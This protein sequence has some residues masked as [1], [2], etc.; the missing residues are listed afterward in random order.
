MNQVNR[1]FTNMSFSLSKALSPCFPGSDP[2][3]VSTLL[4][5]LL[6]IFRPSLHLI[7]TLS[8]HNTHLQKRFPD[9]RIMC[10]VGQK[11]WQVWPDDFFTPVMKLSRAMALLAEAYSHQE[12][13]KELL[14]AQAP[15][16]E[17]ALEKGIN[18]LCSSIPILAI[19]Y[20]LIHWTI[21]IYVYIWI[22]PNNTFAWQKLAEA[23]K[24]NGDWTKAKSAFEKYYQ[25][26]PDDDKYHAHSLYNAALG[27]IKLAPL[28]PPSASSS[29]TQP[30]QEVQS[31][32]TV[33]EV[34]RLYHLG[35]KAEQAAK[36]QW[37]EY[38][39]YN[40]DTSALDDVQ[41]FLTEHG[42]LAAAGGSG[43]KEGAGAGGGTNT[44]TRSAKEEKERMAEFLPDHLRKDA[45]KK[46]K[47]KKKQNQNQK[48]QQQQQ[49]PA[50]SH[51][52]Q[53]QP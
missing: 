27:T 18:Q 30:A 7:S 26:T 1:L 31:N 37:G 49:Q 22:D 4:T 40:F 21:H 14:A 3:T 38:K 43:D 50:E 45:R 25:L 6:R 32:Q 19:H 42:R 8:T 13:D 36:K 24:R 2:D 16:L 15:L 12:E 35:Q 47:M 34:E 17:Q 51:S 44:G 33:D 10:N 46:N 5:K 48:K 20:E 39:S 29:D 41:K 28:A 9:G 52:Q 23:H 53:Q 11:R